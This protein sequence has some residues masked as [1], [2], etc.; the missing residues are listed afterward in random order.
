MKCQR[1]KSSI[2][3]WICGAETRWHRW[4][5]LINLRQKFEFKHYRANS[6]WG[7]WMKSDGLEN[8]VLW[9]KYID[10]FTDIL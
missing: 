3:G 10:S 8:G 4:T 7:N 9:N 6:E 5:R 1:G 2:K